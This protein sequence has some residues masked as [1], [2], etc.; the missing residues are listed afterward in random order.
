MAFTLDRALI[1]I[2]FLFPFFFGGGGGESPAYHYGT[3]L[4]FRWNERDLHHSFDVAARQRW[5][6]TLLVQPVM[7]NVDPAQEYFKQV[8]QVHSR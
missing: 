8:L 3:A 6:R 7:G 4:G 5:A 1:S 2:L